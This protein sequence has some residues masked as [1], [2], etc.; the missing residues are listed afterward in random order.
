MLIVMQN[1][2]R[3]VVSATSYSLVNL[4]TLVSYKLVK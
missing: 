3:S 1:G 2:L 4:F